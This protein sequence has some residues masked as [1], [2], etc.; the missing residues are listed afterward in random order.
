MHPTVVSAVLVEGLAPV[1]VL[2]ASVITVSDDDFRFGGCRG[3]DGNAVLAGFR[4]CRRN[5]SIFV[6]LLVALFYCHAPMCEHALS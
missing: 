3:A 2:A 4:L 6:V 1:V 5:A